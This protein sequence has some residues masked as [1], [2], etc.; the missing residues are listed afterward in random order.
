MR[1]ETLRSTLALLMLVVL[2]FTATAACS[3]TDEPSDLTPSERLEN[4]AARMKQVTSLEFTLS[5]EEGHTPLLLGVVLQG[6]Q[7]TV[8]HPDQASMSVDAEVSA[9]NTFLEMQIEVDGENATMT[10]PLSGVPLELPSSQLPFNLHNLGDTLSGILLA[11][12]AP[13]YSGNESLDGVSSRGIAGAISGANIQ[14]LIPGADG[15]LQQDIE[16]WVGEDDLVRRVR[17]TGKVFANDIAPV[18]RILDFTAF[19]EAQPS[20]RAMPAIGDAGHAV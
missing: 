1:L 12:Q 14:P 3:P 8:Q 16:V 10:D 9:L 6:A 19:D 11:I 4:A 18:I 7:G 20:V 5:H 17:I 13:E 15:T 2:A